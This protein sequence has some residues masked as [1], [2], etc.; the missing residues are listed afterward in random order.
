M[1][2]TN[3]NTNDGSVRTSELIAQDGMEVVGD[4]TRRMTILEEAR[5]N[6]KLIEDGDP[7]DIF[8]KLKKILSVKI[9]P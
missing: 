5:E 7:S 6:G 9:T 1:S 4:S 3:N 8:K 2:E